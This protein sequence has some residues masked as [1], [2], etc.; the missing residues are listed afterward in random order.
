MIIKGQVKY[1]ANYEADIDMSFEDF[2]ALSYTEQKKLIETYIDF[3]RVEFFDTEI[4]KVEGKIVMI[5]DHLWSANT[6]CSAYA[7][8]GECGYIKDIDG[9]YYII[10]LNSKWS[11]DKPNEYRE[12]K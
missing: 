3:D 5:E 12:H 7:H 8:I 6:F 9:D 10:M 2:E 4:E 1:K 11:P